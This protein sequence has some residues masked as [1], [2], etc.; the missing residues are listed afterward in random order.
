MSV[1]KIA[2]EA[3]DFF[4]NACTDIAYT[5]PWRHDD[6]AAKWEAEARANGCRDLPGAY[7]DVLYNDTDMAMDML[8]D[9]LCDEC[10]DDDELHDAVVD[11]L[12][13]G[14]PWMPDSLFKELRRGS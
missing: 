8:G 9:R 13:R 5:E 7:A 6:K 14:M 2:A 11:A 3:L 12:E 1:A 10:G 4:G